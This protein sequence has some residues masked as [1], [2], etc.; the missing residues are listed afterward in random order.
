MDANT[1]QLIIQALCDSGSFTEEQVSRAA[2]FCENDGDPT[3]VAQNL[4]NAGFFTLYQARKFIKGRLT[5]LFFGPYFIQEKIGEGGMGRVYRAIN[6]ESKQLVALK[7]V[8]QALLKNSSVMQRYQREVNAV[9]ALNHPNIVKL[10]E[11][12]EYQGRAYI[13]MEYVHGIDLS[14]LTRKVG[15]LPQR[16]L[17]DPGE[18]CEYIR[19]AALGLHH[20]HEVGF[21]HRDIKPSNLI[22]SGDRATPSSLHNAHVKILDM[23]LVRNIIDEEDETGTELTRHGTVVGTPDYMAPEQGRNSSTVDGRADIYSLGCTLF[24]LLKGQQPFVEGHAIDKLIR[25]QLDPLPDLREL[26]PDLHRDLVA[27]IE[28]MTNKKPD[29]RFSSALEVAELLA[30]FS[31]NPTIRGNAVMPAVAAT[32]TY[33]HVELAA[34]PDAIAQPKSAGPSEPDAAPPQAGGKRLRIVESGDSTPLADILDSMTPTDSLEST[35]AARS[36]S[37][38]AQRTPYS[39]PVLAK[40]V[41]A[42]TRRPKQELPTTTARKLRRRKP[43][44]QEPFFTAPVWLIIGGVVFLLLLFV[45]IMLR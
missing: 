43:K 17:D 24:F 42:E 27:I 25:H 32:P 15:S 30:S 35:Q 29:E 11:A 33:E 28:V 38:P 21:V 7:V 39:T 19:Q 26:R 22:V 20:A 40:P 34:S 41:Q 1:G 9:T 5:D 16:G 12:G 4:L 45:A 8:R 6:R 14:R 10:Y 37:H 31:S 2:T 36:G 44:E 18:A 3:A 23:G 13:A